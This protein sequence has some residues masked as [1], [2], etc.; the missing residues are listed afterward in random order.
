MEFAGYKFDLEE[1]TRKTY[2]ALGLVKVGY[3]EPTESES[4][5]LPAGVF[6]EE[7]QAI[8]ARRRLGNAGGSPTPAE[9]SETGRYETEM[10]AAAADQ[11]AG[12]RLRETLV[13]KGTI[14]SADLG[15]VGLALSGGGIRSATFNLGILESLRPVRHSSPSEEQDH[16]AITLDDV[17]YLSTVSGGGYIGS[18]LSA[19][20]AP[21]PD[22]SNTSPHFPFAHERGKQESVAFKHLRDYSRYLAPTGLLSMIRL[23]SLMLRGLV[24]NFIML[25]PYLLLAALLTV[26]IFGGIIGGAKDNPEGASALLKWGLKTSLIVPAI[27]LL[28]FALYPIVQTV[29][30]KL[31]NWESRDLSSRYIGALGLVIVVAVAFV[32]LQP[33]AIFKMNELAKL[34][35]GGTLPEALTAAAG[36]LTAFV[37]MFSKRMVERSSG[38]LGKIGLGVLAIAGPF[39]LWLIYL[40]FCKWIIF[41]P[42]DG[43]WS[44]VVVDALLD[45]ETVSAAKIKLLNLWPW[46]KAPATFINSATAPILA[47]IPTLPHI[48]SP[49]EW[50]ET[51]KIRMVVYA[52]VA[53]VLILMT[54][55]FYD[56]NRTSIHVFY[57]DRLSKA[58][59]FKPKGTGEVDHVDSLPLHKLDV[60]SVPYHL[61]N[62]TMNIRRSKTENARG[63]DGAPF[64][65]SRNFTGSQLTG[66]CETQE[67]EQA[68]WNLDLGTAMAISGAAAAPNMGKVTVKGLT[69]LMALLNIRLGYW[70]RNPKTVKG[71]RFQK[72]KD[73]TPYEFIKSRLFGVGPI[74]LILELFGSLR[75][76]DRNV[77]LS[78]G[79]H[80][81]NLGIYEL[82]RRRCKFIIACDA[83]ADPDMTF[84]G[85]AEAI[86]LVRIDMGVRI[87]I[88]VDHIRPVPPI[89]L[90]RK[91]VVGT[92]GIEGGDA[93]PASDDEQYSRLHFAVGTIRYGKDSRGQEQIGHLLYI[94]NSVTGDE[95]VDIREYRAK[96]PSFPHE[97]TADQ[98]FDE[99]QFEAYR[100]LG[101]HIGRQVLEGFEDAKLNRLAK[102]CKAGKNPL[103]FGADWLD[104][105]KATWR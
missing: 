30:K 26:G 74:Y 79:G 5:E 25:L 39:V 81:E 21:W 70:L 68:D 1:A 40:T 50:S 87:D 19:I 100:A 37:S 17:D 64:I 56:V 99:T 2:S 76:D 67:M 66:Y 11:P 23:P 57:R 93:L 88:D 41:P 97:T 83:E 29:F 63:R 62:A 61:I 48:E 75:E 36:V 3:H 71:R 65:F 9:T 85:L 55:L 4:E 94:K 18:C 14:P 42:S 86:R 92:I 89:R 32:F 15:L 38:L 44:K 102:Q 72:T 91:G 49:S 35:M 34:A 82:V 52:V 103:Y 6:G 78:D 47:W 28:L 20:Y 90:V 31:M 24:I 43:G 59:L 45:S 104:P 10:G 58:Y 7:L 8:C 51:Q 101:R 46:L 77:N 54:M 33:A 16:P 73:W 13:K 98:F 69:F 12:K 60:R 96:N 84:H 80:F 53:V 27:L 105:F 95:S 22:E